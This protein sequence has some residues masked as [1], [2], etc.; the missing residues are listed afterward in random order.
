MKRGQRREKK[1]R[2]GIHPGDTKIRRETH[3]A[4]R[5]G[6]GSQKVAK[7]AGAQAP[8]KPPPKS[9]LHRFLSVYSPFHPIPSHP[10]PIASCSDAAAA[11]R[12]PCLCVWCSVYSI[13][14]RL[15]AAPGME[16]R[17]QLVN[18]SISPKSTHLCVSRVLQ[19]GYQRQ[20]SG[21]TESI[22]LLVVQAYRTNLL[23]HVRY[24]YS[25]S[26]TRHLPADPLHLLTATASLT[27][28]PVQVRLGTT[29]YTVK[30]VRYQIS[31]TQLSSALTFGDEHE[32]D[33]IKTFLPLVAIELHPLHVGSPTRVAETKL[34]HHRRKHKQETPRP[35]I[36]LWSSTAA[37][38]STTMTIAASLKCA[39]GN[40][41]SY[42]CCL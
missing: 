14:P 2:F 23:P 34:Y 36:P 18:Q 33:S 29:I 15:S 7:A 1:R 12:P 32:M 27:G 41:V 35:A 31:P 40:G 10:P 28:R 5:T 42:F 4:K 8:D 19:G 39:A 21:S 38:R 16:G 6:K 13:C 30:A 20:K 11:N 17:S 26:Y 3:K 24:R 22:L 25:T 37:P 9:R